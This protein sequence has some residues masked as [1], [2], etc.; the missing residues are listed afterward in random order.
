[1]SGKKAKAVRRTA[2]P[3]AA[4]AQSG[5]AGGRLWKN[6]L[7]VLAIV[8]VIG[9]T[10][11]VPKLVSGSSDSSATHAGMAMNAQAG[12]GLKVGAAVP[13]FSESDVE[14]G[15]TISSRSL[16]SER[17][18]LFFSEGVMCQACFAQIKD[19]EQMGAELNARGIKLVSITPDSPAELKQAIAQYG[20]ESPMISDSDRNMSEAFNTLGLGMHSDTPGHAFV[21]I[22]GG[23]V[24]WYHD[25]WLPPERSMYVKPAQVLGDLP[26]A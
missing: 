4:K 21:L 16:A 14:T 11:V 26:S 13:S 20:I 12:T 5:A 10:F 1:M 24:R 23:K 8:A 2:R 9:A 25:Y 19:L 6:A 17:T 7:V 22:A 18:L 3:P 15:Q